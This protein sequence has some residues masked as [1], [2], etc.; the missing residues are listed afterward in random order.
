MEFELY[1][2]CSLEN[3]NDECFNIFIFPFV[4]IIISTIFA[5]VLVYLVRGINEGNLGDE[6]K[7]YFS[8]VVFACTTIIVTLMFILVKTVNKACCVMK[9]KKWNIKS[10]NVK[11]LDE[12]FE[13][14]QTEVNN[15]VDCSVQ[16]QPELQEDVRS[17]PQVIVPR[18][19]TKLN[20][21]HVVVPSISQA[22]I[23]RV[24][25]EAAAFSRQQSFRSGNN[26]AR[27]NEG[28]LDCAVRPFSVERSARE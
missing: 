20:G 27:R 23:N 2:K 10:V 13:V 18:E 16:A 25:R 4:I 3:F 1:R 14:N 17:E 15:H 12:T 9:M 7:V 6:E 5:I 8:L 26:T 11:A 22:T 21:R 19:V 28:N 24:N